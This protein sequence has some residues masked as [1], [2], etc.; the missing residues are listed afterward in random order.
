V[1]GGHGTVPGLGERDVAGA[2]QDVERLADQV[3]GSPGLCLPVLLAQPGPGEVSGLPAEQV[4]L[5]GPDPDERR[6]E[7]ACAAALT[8]PNSSRA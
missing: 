7:R 5:A 1:P 2:L 6:A 8:C 4:L 3:P